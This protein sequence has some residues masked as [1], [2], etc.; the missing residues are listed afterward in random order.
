MESIVVE[1]HGLKME[2]PRAVWSPEG[3]TYSEQYEEHHW[4]ELVS[5]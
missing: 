2:I 1:K 4:K 3:S 5:Q